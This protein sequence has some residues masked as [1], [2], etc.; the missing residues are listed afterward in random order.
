MKT[1]YS[2]D[3][4]T[5]ASYCPFFLLKKGKTCVNFL[6]AKLIR[7]AP[8]CHDIC[9]LA[10]LYHGTLA[11]MCTF[12][13]DKGMHEKKTLGI[14]VPYLICIPRMELSRVVGLLGLLH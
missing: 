9:G 13:S 3:P 6:D 4:Y 2:Q 14:R 5:T 10:Y 7:V 11:K 1:G 12:R 8:K